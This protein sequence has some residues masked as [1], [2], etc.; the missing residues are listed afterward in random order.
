MT[1]FYILFVVL[2]ALLSFVSGFFV[3]WVLD[4]LVKSY[5]NPE[6]VPQNS[7]KIIVDSIESLLADG[8]SA[9]SFIGSLERLLFV[10]DIQQDVH[11]LIAGWL[12]F[13]VAT[14]WQVWSGVF[15]TFKL[16]Q[17]PL[18]DDTY[19]DFNICASRYFRWGV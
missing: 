17:Y 19:N 13:K 5:K 9:G 16:K 6:L 15:D 8:S 18:D 11:F 2:A 3:R 1:K 12:A 4:R 10:I 7:W 14:K